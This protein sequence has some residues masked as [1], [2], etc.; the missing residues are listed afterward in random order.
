VL[1]FGSGGSLVEVYRDRALGLPPLTTT[2]ARRMM[3]GTRIF[4]ALGGVRGRAPVDVGALEKLL[5]RFSQLVVEQPWIKELD[6]NPLLASPERL[7]ALDARI[8]LHDPE[9]AEE[10]LPTTAIRPYP[11]QY[12]SDEETSDGAGVRV[13]PIRPEDEPLMVKFHESLSEQSVYMRY[14]HMM[15]LDQRTAH[16]RL[17][18]ICF[19][20]Y[21]REMAL[22]AERTDPETGEREIMGVSR[23]SRHGAVPREAEFSVLVSDRF[24]RRGLGTLLVGRILE[25]GRAEGLRRIT[26]EILLDNRPMQRISERLG[27]HLRRDT[28]NMVVK[29]ELDLYQRA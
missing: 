3:E 25:V 26:A 18:R 19:I 17:T 14:F 29:A 9:T 24:Q 10:D 22:V 12:V 20:D 16:E 7:T 15:K 27:F 4:E 28:E 1:L 6:I 5:V 21:D 13:R 11:T 2:L 8:V 23:L